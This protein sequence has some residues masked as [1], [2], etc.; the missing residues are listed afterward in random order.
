MRKLIIAS[1]FINFLL[2]AGCL[3]HPYQP[4]VQQGN[5][6][7]PSMM[8]NV[9]PGMSKD[10]VRNTLG[11]PLLSNTFDNNHWGYVYTFQHNGG[12]ITRKNFDIYFQNGRVSRIDKSEGQIAK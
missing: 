12:I 7:S 3:I 5:L 10:Q 4:D 9:K 6:I 11:N 1:L 8:D 2:L